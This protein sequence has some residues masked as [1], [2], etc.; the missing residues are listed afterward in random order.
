M[1]VDIEISN[2][3]VQAFA[4]MIG[5][6]ANGQNISRPVERDPIVEIETLASQNLFGDRP[7][8]GVVGLKAVP[9]Q[10]QKT[11]GCSLLYDTRPLDRLLAFQRSLPRFQ[12]EGAL[13]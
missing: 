4:H 6:P 9:L 7:Q 10:A 5:Q 2:V 3:A 8:T 13:G 12:S 11:W 1:P